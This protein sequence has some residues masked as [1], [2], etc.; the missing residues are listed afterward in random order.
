[1][2]VGSS[3]EDHDYPSSEEG[4]EEECPG[5]PSTYAMFYNFKNLS[6]YANIKILMLITQTLFYYFL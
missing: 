4:M 5:I 1:M 6:K 2:G 3:T